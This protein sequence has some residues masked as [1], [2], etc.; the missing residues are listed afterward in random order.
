MFVGVVDIE[1]WR[2]L[3]RKSSSE[4]LE[5]FSG[6]RFV[7]HKNPGATTK[8]TLAGGTFTIG[9]LKHLYQSLR[10]LVSL[11]NVASVWGI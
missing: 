2:F 5:L 3:L 4:Q 9:G 11:H 8:T 10:K 1:A 6:Y 7:Y